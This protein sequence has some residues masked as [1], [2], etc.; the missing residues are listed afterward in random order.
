MSEV[1]EDSPVK[2][3][4]EVTEIEIEKESPKLGSK[5]KSKFVVNSEH[6]DRVAAASSALNA[7]HSVHSVDAVTGVSDNYD[8][9]IDEQGPESI[10][11]TINLASLGP[12]NVLKTAREEAKLSKEDVA[13]ELRLAVRCVEYLEQDAYHKFPAIAFYIGYL[14]NYAKLLSLDPEKILS[15]FYAI[16]KVTPEAIKLKKIPVTINNDKHSFKSVLLKLKSFLWPLYKNRL[17]KLIT[18][19]IVGVLI[20]WWL[21]SPEDN[22]ITVNSVNNADTVVSS[23]TPE[24]VD[25][26]L[27]T[28]PV[29]VKNDYQDSDN[30]TNIAMIDDNELQKKIAEEY[31]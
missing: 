2:E 10:N 1:L 8:N 13:N 19:V 25:E 4:K 15:K 14:R 9:Y 20:M 5:P 21:L 11:H 26:L 24:Q 12:G 16:H 28:S 29:I 3:I 27:P 23:L 7:N 18:G 6:S 22:M 17:F 30:N 31:S